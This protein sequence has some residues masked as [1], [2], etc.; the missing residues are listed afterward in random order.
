MTT[1]SLSRQLPIVAMLLLLLSS[2]LLLSRN[3]MVESVH[4]GSCSRR[5]RRP[6]IPFGRSSQKDV[7]SRTTTMLPQHDDC[8]TS[9]END[10][11]GGSGATCGQEELYPSPN[12]NQFLIRLVEHVLPRINCRRSSPECARIQQ[13]HD[14]PQQQCNTDIDSLNLLE[15]I[16]SIQRGG[17]GGGGGFFS[18][19]F[20]FPSGYNPFGYKITEFGELFLTFDGSLECDVGRFLA[21][22]KGP[23]RKTIS[24]I[25]SQWLEV[26]RVSKSGQ[27]MRIYRQINELLD[28]CL[29][30]GFIN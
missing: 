18:K 16:I 2:I 15:T 24:T 25:K 27:T 30:A 17:G 1:L 28:F 11:T 9:T 6:I 29:Q 8:L 20:R 12:R 14:L 5:T 10:N 19:I 3:T 7:V 23:N 22:L 4:W 26:L 21:S 13:K